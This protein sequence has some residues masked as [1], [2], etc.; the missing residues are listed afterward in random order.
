MSDKPEPSTQPCV[1]VPFERSRQLADWPATPQAASGHLASSNRGWRSAWPVIE[2]DACN[3]CGL[4]LLYCPDGAITW[5][6]RK[7][8][9][10]ADDWCKGCGMC[11]VE[12]P[13]HI[14]TLSAEPESVRA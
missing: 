2:L 1:L 4:C 11:V 9:V 14:I 5:N 6:E 12:C 8:P 7:L 13:K 3:S 10:V